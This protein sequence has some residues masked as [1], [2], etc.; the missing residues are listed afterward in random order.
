VIPVDRRRKRSQYRCIA[1][2][3]GWGEL[4]AGSWELGAGSYEL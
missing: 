1:V 4:G 3:A 2:H